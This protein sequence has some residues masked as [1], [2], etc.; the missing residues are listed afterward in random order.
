MGDVYL[1]SFL[2]RQDG[3]SYLIRFDTYQICCLLWH[4]LPYFMVGNV[5]P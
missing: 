4:L 1:I 2:L 3:F 5:L